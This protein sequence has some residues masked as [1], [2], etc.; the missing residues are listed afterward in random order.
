MYVPWQL[1][2]ISRKGDIID[3]DIQRAHLRRIII[4]PITSGRYAPTDRGRILFLYEFY[5]A[6][7][8]QGRYLRIIESVP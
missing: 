6:V 5:D 8:N 4:A 1:V 2:N 3:E 7:V